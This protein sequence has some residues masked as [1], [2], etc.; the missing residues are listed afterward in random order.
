MLLCEIDLKLN[1]TRD[2]QEATF[3]NLSKEAHRCQ[4][5]VTE[6]HR[7]CGLGFDSPAGSPQ[8]LGH[9]EKQCVPYIRKLEKY[10]L[11]YRIKTSTNKTSMLK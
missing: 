5:S 1:K 11:S 6:P 10:P 9:Y 7:F 4:V 8:S 3:A 2:A